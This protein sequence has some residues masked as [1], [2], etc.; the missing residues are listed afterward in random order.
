MNLVLSELGKKSEYKTEYDPTLLFPIP[1]T[2]KR[3]ELG[4]TAKPTFSGVDIWTAFEVSWLNLKGKPQV[5]IAIFEID[6][7]S[8]CLIESKSFKLYLNSFNNSRFADDEIVIKTMQED[9]EKAANGTVK[10]T[11]YCLTDYPIQVTPM[12]EAESLDELDVEITEYITNPNFLSVNPKVIVHECLSSDLLKSNCL[13]TF[14][15]DWGSVLIEYQ[16]AK[17]DKVGLLKYIISFRNHNEFHEQ[18]VERIYNDI[19]QNCKPEK[20]MVYARYSRRGGLDINPLR[21]N[22]TLAE[23]LKTLRLARQ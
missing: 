22:F 20:L 14:Q 16:G 23:K 10:V 11:L 9:L 15:P 12:F 6:A 17:I 3:Q 1:R 8:Q 19:M 13:V 7:L 2:I 21:S 18:C 5:R 4:I